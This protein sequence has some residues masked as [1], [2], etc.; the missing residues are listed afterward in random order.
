MFYSKGAALGDLGA[1]KNLE[2][3]EF[4]GEGGPADHAEAARWLT[5]FAEGK[6]A[7]SCMRLAFMYHNGDGV[8][9]DEAKAVKLLE[10]ACALGS[11]GGLPNIAT[12]PAV[13]RVE[14]PQFPPVCY[15][16]NR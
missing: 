4:N 12:P 14:W 13:M 9:Q 3:M 10:E 16:S 5:R 2:R 15:L 11:A 1:G 7:D 6:D 8:S